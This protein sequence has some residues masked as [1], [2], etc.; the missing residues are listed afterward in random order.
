MRNLILIFINI[1]KR[2]AAKTAP[3]SLLKKVFSY[4]TKSFDQTFSKVCGFQRQ[5]LWSPSADGEIPQTEAHLQG[6]N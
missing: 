1:T 3:F 4:K 5:S 2:G 6:V